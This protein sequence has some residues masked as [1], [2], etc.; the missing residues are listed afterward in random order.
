MFHKHKYSLMGLTVLATLFLGGLAVAQDRDHD[1][2]RDKDRDDRWGYQD[3]DR[4]RD[5][6]QDR[7]RG[8]NRDR[9]RD[10]DRDQDAYRNDRGFFRGGDIARDWGSRDGFDAARGD[11]RA[12]KSFNSSPRGRYKHSDRGYQRYFGDKREYQEQYA[13]AYRE[14][15]ERA[16]EHGGWRR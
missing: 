8:W 16:W 11:S 4:D 13:R 10:R 9:D 2:D 12:R 5:E 7:D 14:S 6:D 1:R 3:R 15:Y